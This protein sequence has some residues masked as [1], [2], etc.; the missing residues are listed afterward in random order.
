MTDTIDWLERLELDGFVER[1]VDGVQ[2][3]KRW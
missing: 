2:T 3:T 1:T